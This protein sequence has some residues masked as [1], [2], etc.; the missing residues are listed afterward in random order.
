MTHKPAPRAWKLAAVVLGLAAAGSP[1]FRL[2]AA[3]QGEPRVLQRAWTVAGAAV[4]SPA[5]DDSSAYFL[6]KS[7]EVLAI[8][9]ASGRIRWRHPTNESGYGGTGAS[10]VVSGSVVVAGDDNLLAFDRRS[11]VPRWRFVPTDGYGPGFYLSFSATADGVVYAGSPSGRFYAVDAETGRLRWST[12]VAADGKTTVF[13]P[14]FQ[15]TV[16]AAGYT[17]FVAPN[18]GGLVLLDTRTG[19]ILWKRAFP[20]PSDHSLSVNW[21]GGP[22]FADDLVIVSSGDGVVHAFDTASGEERWAIP[23]LSGRIGNPIIS[24]DRDFRG[25]AVSGQLLVSGSLTGTIVAYDLATRTERWRHLAERLG[26]VM[27]RIEASNEIVYV[28][29]AGGTLVALRADDG[30]E[31][32]RVGDWMAS[33]LWPPAFWNDLIIVSGAVDGFS[34]FR[35][36]TD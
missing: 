12:V 30:I 3:Q 25:L 9:A 26:S 8:D 35:R 24:P 36:I 34:A 23:A 28:P 7:H 5:T 33:L 20:Q 2:A 10:V 29:F 22:V 11:G 1:P 14:R 27:F 32:W 16:V 13:P 15:G 17:E 31:Q 18:R 19:R 4:G 6:S 21:A